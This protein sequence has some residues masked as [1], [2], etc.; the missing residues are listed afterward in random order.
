VRTYLEKLFTT[1]IIIGLVEWLKVKAP[2]S[3]SSNAKKK[4]KLCKYGISVYIRNYYHG[5]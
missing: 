5:Y 4:R 2:S 3:S 1:K